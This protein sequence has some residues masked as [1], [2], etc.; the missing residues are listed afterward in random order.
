MRVMLITVVLLVDNQDMRPC[1]T[2]HDDH[3]MW[4]RSN[5]IIF[6]RCS[7]LHFLHSNFTRRYYST[8]RLTYCYVYVYVYRQY[9]YQ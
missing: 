9:M 1:S 6:S 7:L 4:V 5:V 2:G 3:W 8:L